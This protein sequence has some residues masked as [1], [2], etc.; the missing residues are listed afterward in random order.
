MAERK[1]SRA[2]KPAEKTQGLAEPKKQEESKKIDAQ[3]TKLTC[4][5]SEAPKGKP[6]STAKFLIICAVLA[7]VIL[8]SVLIPRYLKNKEFEDNKYNNFEFVKT[9]DGFW[10]TVVQKG[11]QSYRIP[12]YYHPRDLEDIG[13]ERYLRAKFFE[14]KENG[15]QI[16]IT[17]DPDSTN[18]KIVIAGVE[19]ARITGGKYDLLNVPTGSAFIKQ[20]KEQSAET[21]T[22]IITCKNANNQT[23]VIWL[24]IS[25]VNVISSE[26]YCVILEAKTYEDLIRGADR[27]MYH[28]LGIMD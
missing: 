22:P 12:F 26:G 6:V 4:Q 5:A 19:I 27:L 28:L 11:V 24:T 18:N 15:G 25:D 13:V 14:I 17:L 2:K 21:G 3:S 10:M 16:F 20:P 23:L 1:K 8:G 7:I 9:D